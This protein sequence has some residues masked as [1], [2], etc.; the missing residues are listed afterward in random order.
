MSTH[1]TPL[2]PTTGNATRTGSPEA[3]RSDRDVA[4]SALEAAAVALNACAA[5]LRAPLAAPMPAPAPVV[6]EDPEPVTLGDCYAPP[7]S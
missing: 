5:L 3:P 1:A 7:L 6:R 2:W 4:A